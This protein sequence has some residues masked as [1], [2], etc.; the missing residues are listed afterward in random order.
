MLTKLN[1]TGKYTTHHKFVHNSINPNN[2]SHKTQ[3]Y[4]R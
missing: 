3:R 2:R 4:S 1:N